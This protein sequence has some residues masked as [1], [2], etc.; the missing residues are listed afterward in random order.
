MTGAPQGG[1]PAAASSRRAELWQATRF[2]VVG[3]LGTLV[4]LVVFVLCHGGL[5]LPSLGA[6]VVAFL[7]ALQHN[8]WWHRRV[9][10][11]T[12]IDDPRHH[13]RYLILCTA[14]LAV[15]LLVLWLLER[16]GVPPTLA[17]AAGIATATPLNYVG[18]RN[19]VFRP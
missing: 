14:T 8:L 2:L 5:G 10:F 3:G 18:S 6:S 19:W 1:G 12:A 11:D 7:V 15:N 16:A 17:Q 4:N 9:T 13:H